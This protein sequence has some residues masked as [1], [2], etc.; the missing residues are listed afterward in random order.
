MYEKL[1]VVTIK[2]RLEEL[3]ERFNTRE[4]AKFYIEHMGL[5]FADYETEHG[6]YMSAV[7]RLRHDLDR[8]AKVQVVERSFLPNFIFTADDLI[9]TVGQDGLVVNTAKYLHG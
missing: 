9:V 7:S 5:S 1:V 4:Q 2:T 8:L 6:T 3:I